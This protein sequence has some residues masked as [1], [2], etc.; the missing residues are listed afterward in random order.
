MNVM[1]EIETAR[2]IFISWFALSGSIH[3]DV[4]KEWFSGVQREI[5]ESLEKHYIAGG[6][7]Y[8]PT[9]NMEHYEL[10]EEIVQKYSGVVSSATIEALRVGSIV[11][12]AKIALFNR[13]KLDSISEVSEVL[14]KLQSVESELLDILGD[15]QQENKYNHH[16]SVQELFDIIE[17]GCKNDKKI[18][19]YSTGIEKLD[20]V[21]NGIQ[22]GK[23][24]VIGALKKT[25]KSRLKVQ[26]AQTAMKQGAKVL[27]NSL[28]MNKHELNTCALSYHSGV[29][30][31]RI[32]RPLTKKELNSLGLGGGPLFNNEWDIVRLKTVPELYSYSL[33]KQK[34]GGLNIVFVDFL[35]RMSSLKY[36]KDRVREVEDISIQLAD[37]AKNLDVAVIALAQLSGIA[38]KLK[39]EEMPDMQHFKESQGIAENAD[40][41]ITQHNPYR[42]SG[43]V[44][45][46]DEMPIW[47]RVQQRYGISD[48]IIKTKADLSTCKFIDDL[49]ENEK[50]NW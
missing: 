3:P 12:R 25:G 20:E 21:M 26:I 17:Q 2:K 31:A 15:S 45:N 28:E 22:P 8:D 14:P 35:Q 16:E 23:F 46:F 41:I 9:A 29:D 34:R 19:G 37:M 50:E 47:F 36:P 1:Q 39:E 13:F 44:F 7:M 4:K 10:I 6:K 5:Y 32:G 18:S 27:C 48:V 49:T 30:S 38:E 43:K 40:V 24:I 42:T 33:T 11:D